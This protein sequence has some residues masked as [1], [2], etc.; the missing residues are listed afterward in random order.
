MSLLTHPLTRLTLSAVLLSGCSS[1]LPERPSEGRHIE[2]PA[3]TVAN[4]DIPE[5]VR[6]R[7]A[8]AS[9][10]AQPAP[11]LFT[12]IVQDTPVRELMFRIS[13]DIGINIDIHPQV[14]GNVSINAVDQTL[15]QI[16][17]RINRQV[18]FRWRMDADNTLVI[19]P[20]TP[21]LRTYRIDYVNVTREANTG[22]SVATSLVQV[23]GA[24]GGAAGG[25]NNSTASINQSS[26]NDFW[27][28][29]EANIR[30]LLDGTTPAGNNQPAPAEPGQPAGTQANTPNM[31]TS[32]TV[33]PES[34]LVSVYASARQHEDIAAFIDLVRNRSLTQVLIEATVV[35]VTLNDDNQS[36]VDW[37]V[38]SRDGGQLD[39]VQSVTGIN[40]NTPPAALLT[41]D[42]SSGPDAIAATI[43]MLSTFGESRVLSSPKIMALNNQAAM[44]R[45]VDN[46]VYFTIEVEPG[47]P[48]TTVSPATPAVYTS[49]VNTVPV[50]FVMSVT[51]QIGEN[52]QVTLNVRPTISRIVRFVSDPNP[53]LAQAGVTNFVPE[54]QIREI[55]SILKVYSGQ[56][57]VLGGL[58]QDSLES[59]TAGLPVASRLP[60]LRNLFSYRQDQGRKT[61]LI[62]FIR[63]VV[64]RQPSLDGDLENYQEYLPENGLEISDFFSNLP[65]PSSARRR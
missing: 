60:L 56:I 52:D 26:S 62:V 19:E 14:T 38:I 34:G 18:S 55:E 65:V 63:P 61:E 49:T 20:D 31:Q 27:G 5:V 42:R 15:T 64:V 44:L 22:L 30:S 32:V 57:A 2:P 21:F 4:N 7:P 17:D 58:M 1:S 41:I 25:S 33:N 51:P 29:L 23:G 12:V 36:G 35:E 28:T 46:R 13:R 40:L 11:E 24:G 47:T 43:R 10:V 39:F 53:A 8:L 16:I 50:G 3:A 37:T 48:A 59:T 9:P 54:I 6:P 45:V